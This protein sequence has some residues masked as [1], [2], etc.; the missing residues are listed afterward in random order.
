MAG[1]VQAEL[2]ALDADVELENLDTLEGTYAF[3]R[4]FMDARSKLRK[5]RASCAESASNSTVCR[6]HFRSVNVTMQGLRHSG[7]GRHDEPAKGR[8]GSSAQKRWSRAREK[9]LPTDARPTEQVQ[10]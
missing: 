5:D 7:R 4:D 6:R 9:P 8:T 10:L 1:A 2:R 3:D